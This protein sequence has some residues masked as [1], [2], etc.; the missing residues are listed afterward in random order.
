[1]AL[2]RLVHDHQVRRARAPAPLDANLEV[3]LYHDDLH[4]AVREATQTAFMVGR[5]DQRRVQAAARVEEMLQ[6]AQ[7]PACRTSELV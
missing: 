1:M 7:T 5:Y 3:G 6:Y 2:P 4:P